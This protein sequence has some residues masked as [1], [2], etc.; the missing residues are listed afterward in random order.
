MVV[1]EYLY[2][3]TFLFQRSSLDVEQDEDV[4]DVG[5]DVHVYIF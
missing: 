4:V 1:Q 5:V 2:I 3:I